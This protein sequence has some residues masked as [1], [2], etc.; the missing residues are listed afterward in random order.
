MDTLHV[1]VTPDD[2][3]RERVQRPGGDGVDPDVVGS[4]L[5]GKQPDLVF[6]GGLGCAHD[7]VAGKRALRRLKG[8][9]KYASA[10]CRHQGRAE[11]DDGQ[12]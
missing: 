5:C 11:P 4:K 12:Q 6:Q 10:V 1:P 3:R 9:R 2:P 8:H 7:V